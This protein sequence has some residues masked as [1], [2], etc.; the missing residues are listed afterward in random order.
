MTLN[1]SDRYFNL[2][3]Y[4][5]MSDRVRTANYLNNVR[6]NKK[7]NLLR[8]PHYK[9]NRNNHNLHKSIPRETFLIYSSYKPHQFLHS[10]RSSDHRAGKCLPNSVKFCIKCQGMYLGR[11]SYKELK[12]IS[13]I[14]SFYQS[15]CML[16]NSN[17]INCKQLYCSNQNQRKNQLD[18]SLYR[19]C[20]KDIIKG[21]IKN[22]FKNFHLNNS[23]TPVDSFGKNYQLIKQTL[24]NN[25]NNSKLMV[26]YMFCTQ[27]R[28]PNTAHYSNNSNFNSSSN[29]KG[30]LNC[31]RH[32]DS[33]II[34][35]PASY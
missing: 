8:K 7:D 15:K 9:Q 33:H 19:H 3:K 13:T 22:K 26:H 30:C 29:S 11:Q 18:K 16:S 21:N 24:L 6:P 20:C 14:N 34:S 28:K 25:L 5:I 2:S 10:F 12:K 23:D 32:T 4:G 31:T 27:G 35:S 1:K 17:H